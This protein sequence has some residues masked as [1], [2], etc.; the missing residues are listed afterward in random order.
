MEA[1]STWRVAAEATY[2][3]IGDSKAD[4]TFR[5]VKVVLKPPP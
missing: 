2:S 4:V 1:P 5:F 3:L